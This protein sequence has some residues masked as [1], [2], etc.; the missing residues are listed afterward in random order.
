MHLVLPNHAII[1]KFNATVFIII[2]IIWMPKQ[3]GLLVIHLRLVILVTKRV[4]HCF[5]RCCC[6]SSLVTL[7]FLGHLILVFLA[8]SGQ[9]T[10]WRNFI[11]FSSLL[12]FLL[13]LLLTCSYLL[14]L[15][16][17]YAQKIL[18]GSNSNKGI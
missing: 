5:P 17:R 2:V 9:G 1:V 6:L 11:V 16:N 8:L 12:L 14:N 13:N 18:R 4:I 7:E 15:S 3:V 10:I